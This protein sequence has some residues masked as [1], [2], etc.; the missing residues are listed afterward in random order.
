MEKASITLKGRAL[1]MAV[2]AG[3]IQEKIK[4]RPLGRGGD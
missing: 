3:L 1:V 2:D 4:I